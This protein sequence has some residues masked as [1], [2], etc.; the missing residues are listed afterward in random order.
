M[1][2]PV[3]RAGIDIAGGETEPGEHTITEQV[4]EWLRLSGQ[5]R[6]FGVKGSP[7]PLPGGK[8]MSLSVIDKMP[9]SKGRPIPGGVRLWHLNT[10]MLK[11]A[12]WARIESKRF[13]LHAE[14]EETYASHLTAEAKERD[15]YGRHIWVIQG[16]RA[17]HLLDCEVYAAAMADP[18]CWGGV[19]VLPRPG[20]PK[21]AAPV[22][23]ED[24]VNPFTGEPTGRWLKR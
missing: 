5:G 14:A 18:E 9:G 4:Y 7:R 16:R 17:N 12:I 8:K 13:W 11:D 21:P 1:A 19:L 2:Y 23:R 20:P 6:V 24:E 3:W 15:K 22:D 10:V